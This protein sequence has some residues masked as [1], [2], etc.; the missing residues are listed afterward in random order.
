[1]DDMHVL[2]VHTKDQNVIYIYSTDWVNHYV[3][4]ILRQHLT[5]RYN[6]KLNNVIRMVSSQNVLLFIFL[7]EVWPFLKYVQ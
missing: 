6:W 7:V 1:M 5:N 4:K 3:G 2:C